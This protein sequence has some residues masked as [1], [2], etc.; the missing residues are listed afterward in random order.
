M[1]GEITVVRDELLGIPPLIP[2]THAVAGSGI[3]GRM[4]QDYWVR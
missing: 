2:Q 3:V 4:N 1:V